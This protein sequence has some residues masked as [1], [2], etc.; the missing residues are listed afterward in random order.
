MQIL[1]G[2]F[3]ENLYDF[4]GKNAFTEDKYNFYESSHYRK[5]VGDGIMAI[6]YK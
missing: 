2:L 5:K 1:K 6:I 3:G 4:S